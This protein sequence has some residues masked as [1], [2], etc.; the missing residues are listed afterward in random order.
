M[1]KLFKTAKVL[2]IAKPG[3]DPKSPYSYRPISM[4]NMLDKAFEKIILDRLQK[5][6]EDNNIIRSE[7]FVFRKEQKIIH[8]V[9][10]IVN[11]LQHFKDSRKSTGVVFLDIKKAFSS[12]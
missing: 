6:T 7:K 3:K 10:R 9:K 8:Q 1:S 2:P 5:F 4:L 11:I 12:I